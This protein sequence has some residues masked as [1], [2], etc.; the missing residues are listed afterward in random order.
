MIG[1]ETWTNRRIQA[2]MYLWK[3][4][5]DWAD[6]T[7]MK[8]F[9]WAQI[10]P[11]DQG[12]NWRI[13]Y[14][15]RR[16]EFRHHTLNLQERNWTSETENRQTSTY[17]L[18]G[19][20]KHHIKTWIA[21]AR[22]THTTRNFDRIQGKDTQY[23]GGARQKTFCMGQSKGIDEIKEPDVKIT[24]RT[25]YAPSSGRDELPPHEMTTCSSQTSRCNS[26]NVKRK[27]KT[28]TH[29][30][31]AVE[32]KEKSVNGEPW[33]ADSKMQSA[34]ANRNME[35]SQRT[36]LQEKQTLQKSE[37]KASEIE[38]QVSALKT[39]G[40]IREWET[41]MRETNKPKL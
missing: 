12:F 19:G 11:K 30:T 36:H 34:T 35:Y 17:R 37:I 3:R 29:Q 41:E 18:P 7:K 25:P 31:L 13:E 39:H 40:I 8:V 15:P 6:T 21:R 1:V 10:K 24:C 26:W 27:R 5:E 33:N 22:Q 28:V 20:R 9:L 32:C 16:Q 2:D 38:F 4:R 23:T 14:T